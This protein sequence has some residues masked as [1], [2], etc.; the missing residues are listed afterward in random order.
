MMPRRVTLILVTLLVR[1]LLWRSQ[2]KPHIKLIQWR[3]T[4]VDIVWTGFAY[5][6]L[7]MTC[8]WTHSVHCMHSLWFLLNIFLFQTTITTILRPFFRDHPGELVPEE[9]F[10]TLWCTGRLTEANTPTIRLSTTPSGLSSAHLHHSPC[11]FTGRIPFLPP[12]QQCQSTEGKFFL[13]QTKVNKLTSYF[14]Q[15]MNCDVIGYFSF[16][17]L[18]QPVAMDRPLYFPAVVYVFFLL[19]SSPILSGCRV[20]VYHTST[21]DVTL[22]RI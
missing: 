10:L 13:F 21:C 12:N 11:F 4:P 5:C 9:N 22:V 3:G 20:D 17:W 14:C 19:F 18:W 8:P 16:S 6:T 15:M 1:L 7:H 2:M